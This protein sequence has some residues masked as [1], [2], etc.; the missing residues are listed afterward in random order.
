MGICTQNIKD[1]KFFFSVLLDAFLIS[2]FINFSEKKVIL[3]DYLQLLI[4][5]KILQVIYY[6]NSGSERHFGGNNA[7]FNTSSWY[8]LRKTRH[9]LAGSLRTKIIVVSLQLN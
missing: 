3:L 5:L 1:L 4:N 6:D 7:E 2:N 9:Q 8:L